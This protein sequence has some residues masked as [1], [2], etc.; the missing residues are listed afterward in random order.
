MRLKQI[1]LF[2]LTLY[3]IVLICLLIL[4][5]I[6]GD[7][8][9]VAMYSA[10]ISWFM[11]PM[12]LS[13]PLVMIPKNIVHKGFGVLAMFWAVVTL[14]SYL[15][16]IPQPAIA[17]DSPTL[18]VITYNFLSFNVQA[19]DS[20]RLFQTYN[21]D[22]MFF[23]ETD[24]EPVLT[25]LERFRA[26]YPHEAVI[27]PD[28]RILSKYPFIEPPTEL[29]GTAGIPS[30]ILRA[31]IDFNNQPIAVY[32][33]HLWLPNDTPLHPP[34][35]GEAF[36]FIRNSP[37]RFLANYDETHRNARLRD[38][39]N[40]VRQES[41]PVILAGDFNL[42]ASSRAYERLSSVLVDAQRQ[43]GNPFQMTWPNSQTLDN[44]LRFLPPLIRI[45]YVWH[46][47][48][49]VSTNVIVGDAFGSDHYPLIVDLRFA[50]Q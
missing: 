22:V 24:R 30:Y 43:G 36:Y 26:D 3:H 11:L 38:L 45:D 47:P 41:Y 37:L 8:W 23:Q 48:S 17:Q 50:A 4:R 21:P 44:S 20:I 49:L 42:S 34:F 18:R 33:I 12:F 46:S 7:L 16:P 35:D 25:A 13:I 10:F 9:W 40:Q 6:F 29:F 15:A 39:V 14:F 1:G 27:S 28:T 32:S 2:I 31:V 19:N 5:F